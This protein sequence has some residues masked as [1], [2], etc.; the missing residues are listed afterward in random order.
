M[1]GVD[2][3]PVAVLY[4]RKNAEVLG[5]NHIDVQ[6]VDFESF[7]IHEYEAIHIDPDRRGNNRTVQGDFF[8]P[9]LPAVVDRIGEHVFA[10]IKTAPATPR[11]SCLPETAAFEWIGNRRECKQQLVHLNHEL[12]VTEQYKAT[13][14]VDGGKCYHFSAEKKEVEQLA[15]IASKIDSHI[16]EPHSSILAGRMTDALAIRYGLS[17][18]ASDIVYLTG[19]GSA[20]DKMM[21]RFR[22]DAVLPLDLRKVSGYLREHSIGSLEVK[23]RGIMKF[24]VEKFEKLKTSGE[25]RAVLF[26]TRHVANQV[27]IIAGRA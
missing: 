21:R 20:N 12:P 5:L 6:E 14:V 7:A 2:K 4:A 8:Q 11:H 1:S 26:L 13:R 25:N 10:T 9:P 17:R 27:A 3:D 19:D 24:V 18:L 22:V 16:Y 15:E 23:N